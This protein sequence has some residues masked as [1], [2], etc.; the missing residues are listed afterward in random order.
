MK[1]L[2][3]EEFVSR[4]KKKHCDN[5][6]YS[7][8]EYKHSQTKVKIICKTHGVFEQI[9]DTHLQGNGC[10]KCGL[11]QNSNLRKSNKETFISKSIAIH[12]EKYEYFL[13]EY[14]NSKTKGKIICKEHGVFEQTPNSH[15]RGHG[16]IKCGNQFAPKPSKLNKEIFITKS[17]AIHGDTYDYSLLDYV[18]TNTKIKI[19]CKD[20]GV[21][22]QSPNSH[23]QG[24]GCYKCGLIKISNFRKSNK[25]EFIS[26]AKLVHGNTYDY[27]LFEYIGVHTKGEIVCKKHGV[28]EQQ[29]NNHL[30]GN[31]CQ[32]CTHRISKP[33]IAWLD[34]LNILIRNYSIKT[35][36]RRKINVDGYDPLTNTVYQF[37]GDYWHGN[38]NVFNLDDINPTSKVNYRELYEKTLENNKSIIDSGYKL[39]T[40]WENDFYNLGNNQS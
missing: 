1:L 30:S 29:P 2:T 33:E 7:L 3:K 39:I 17:T 28:F 26:K 12:K 25:E 23:L 8:V 37:H 16:C 20:H 19:I 36:N 32:K 10:Y 14:I 9:P 34:S 15:L 18:N 4:A 31:G 40:I 11:I 24:I 5:Y 6:D 38:P 27:S 35:I 13:F 21:F 22:E